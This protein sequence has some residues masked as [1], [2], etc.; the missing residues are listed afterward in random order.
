[1]KIDPEDKPAS[2]A[3]RWGLPLGIAAGVAAASVAAVTVFS[4]QGTAQPV[5]AGSGG[6]PTGAAASPSAGRV[7]PPA[8]AGTGST[9]PSSP[10]ASP[11]SGT[12]TVTG[13]ATTPIAP[14]TATK[15]LASCLGSDASGYHAV[16]A[17]RTPAATTDWDGAVI[18]VD[19]A[20]Q[21]VQC[22]A[23]GEKGS[24][25]DH[26]PTFVNNRL[27]GTGHLVEYFDSVG[28]PAGS[29]RYLSL[30]AGHYT[31]GIAKITVSYGEDAAEYPAVMAG[32]AFFYS[33][34][35]STGTPAPKYFSATAT[36][37]VHAYDAAG[38]EVYDQKK[39]PQFAAGSQ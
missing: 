28:E 9:R 31:S 23:K 36:P 38:K 11:A 35:F 25:Q 34:A 6:R 3:R 33:A 15:I 37:Y 4:G 5:R 21:Y 13:T 22:E 14:G 29:G 30:G 17:V 1:M 20:G 32:G 7:S 2:F 24:S 8:G 26:P 10:S 39:D 19:S 16:I 18:A 27:W 12:F